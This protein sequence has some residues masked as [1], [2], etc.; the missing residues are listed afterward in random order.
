MYFLKMLS[1]NF[2]NH[3]TIDFLPQHTMRSWGTW[4]LDPTAIAIMGWVGNVAAFVLFLSPMPTMLRVVRARSTL[5]FSISPYVS[6]MLNC[7]LWC[8]YAVP[9]VTANRTLPLVCNTVGTSF[10]LF[11][12]LVYLAFCKRR[13]YYGAVVLA[14]LLVPA[15]AA[16]LMLVVFPQPVEYYT[17]GLGVAA[18]VLNIFM[19]AS[20]LTIIGLVVRTRSVEYMPLPITLA[21]GFC[22]CSWVVYGIYVGD[23]YITT[24][25]MAGSGGQGAR[26]GGVCAC[27]GG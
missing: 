10:Q 19:Y 5:S 13:A 17:T 12:L 21:C 16:L 11:Y 23:I 6:A 14:T 20:P 9:L 15:A 1:A 22:S 4:P 18:T 2:E 26:G 27:G 24:V 25:R 8:L 3:F 7:S